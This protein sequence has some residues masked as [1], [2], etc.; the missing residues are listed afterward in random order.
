MNNRSEILVTFLNKWQTLEGRRQE[1]SACPNFFV[2]L[3]VLGLSHHL[4][5]SCH[6]CPY[7]AQTQTHADTCTAIDGL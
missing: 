7:S 5:V 2:P 1:V 3:Q 4:Q 6:N